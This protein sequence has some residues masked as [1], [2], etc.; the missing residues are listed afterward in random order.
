MLIATVAVA[1]VPRLDFKYGLKLGNL[2]STSHASNYDRDATG[3]LVSVTKV[4]TMDWLQVVPAFLWQTKRG[5]FGEVSVPLWQLQQ[6]ESRRTSTSNVTVTGMARKINLGVQYTYAIRLLKKKTN[7]W[8]PMIGFGVMPYVQHERFAPPS[9][10]EFPFAFTKGG[11]ETSLNPR[12]MWLPSSRFFLD[13]GLQISALDFS[14]A[15]GYDGDPRLPLYERHTVNWRLA[16]GRNGI[17]L[18]AGV[19]L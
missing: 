2:S 5:D 7:Q 19:K 9:E 8:I 6:Q 11:I 13:L 12:V 3:A 10:T 17:M 1:Q 15:S 16:S 18:G 4:R 14:V